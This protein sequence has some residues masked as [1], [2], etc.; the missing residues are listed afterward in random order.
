ITELEAQRDE[1]KAKIKSLPQMVRRREANI[2]ENEWL[3]RAS[4]E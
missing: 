4:Y 3:A 1:L 2:D